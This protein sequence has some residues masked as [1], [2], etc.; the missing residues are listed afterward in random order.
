MIFPP[1]FSVCLNIPSLLGHLETSSC[2][3]TISPPFLVANLQSFLLLLLHIWESPHPKLVGKWLRF[4]AFIIL[5]KANQ[6][7]IR[8]CDISL[9]WTRVSWQ[10]QQD[11]NCPAGDS[12]LPNRWLKLGWEVPECRGSLKAGAGARNGR[13]ISW[14]VLVNPSIQWSSS[15]VP[16][17]PLVGNGLSSWMYV[18]FAALSLMV[19][20]EMGYKFNAINK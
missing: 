6:F 14:W 15:S 13:E 4:I 2:H 1:M 18:L 20:G 3:V 11:T 17:T 9:L 19:Q 12:R 5:M 7:A 10:H 16:N 8:Y